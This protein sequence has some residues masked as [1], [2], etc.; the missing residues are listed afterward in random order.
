MDDLDE[1]LHKGILYALVFGVL[2]ALV[3]NAYMRHEIMSTEG[4]SELFFRNYENLP[5]VMRL[6]QSYNISFTFVNHEAK[7]RYYILEF[8]S[9]DKVVREEFYLP[10]DA[11]MTVTI[12]IS[13]LNQSWGLSYGV[14]RKQR[15]SRALE[16]VNLENISF[17][18]S[19][20][21]EIL[22]MNV[23]L[24]ELQGDGLS[25]TSIEREVIRYHQDYEKL[26]KSIILRGGGG[27]RSGSIRITGEVEEALRNVSGGFTFETL[28][29]SMT[30]EEDKTPVFSNLTVREVN[31]SLDLNQNLEEGDESELSGYDLRYANRT[32]CMYVSGDKVI[33]ESHIIRQDFQIID[34]PFIARL[35]EKEEGKSEPLEIH[36]WSKII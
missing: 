32:L 13:P 2:L 26:N 10:K 5:D 12:T 21:G 16:S 34:K 19:G 17:S 33:T 20:M 23:S 11:S 3:F 35:Y 7:E 24:E 9:P 29:T 4:F 22:H 36:F 6:N 1:G 8:D 30:G 25:H 27:N 15:Q 28:N 31:V 14:D 18:M